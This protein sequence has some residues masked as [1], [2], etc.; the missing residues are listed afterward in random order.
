MERAQSRQKFISV[1]W[2]VCHVA[3]TDLTGATRLVND[4]NTLNGPRAPSSS[5][6]INACR[7][8]TLTCCDLDDPTWTKVGL[9]AVMLRDH[10]SDAGMAI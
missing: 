1:G 10:C 6:K 9:E 7:S 2:P 8:L 5:T 4:A 3:R